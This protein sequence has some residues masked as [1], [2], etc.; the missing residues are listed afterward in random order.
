MHER[1]GMQNFRT[2]VCRKKNNKSEVKRIKIKK[3][4]LNNVKIRTIFLYFNFKKISV[5]INC[6]FRSLK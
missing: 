4:F 1:F 6:F 5:L 3:V 2:K